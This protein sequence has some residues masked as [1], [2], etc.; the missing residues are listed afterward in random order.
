MSE[1]NT[2]RNESG[3]K[4][5]PAHRRP[6]PALLIVVAALSVVLWAVAQY[7]GD[8]GRQNFQVHEQPR[9]IAE[10]AFVDRA[11]APRSLASFA[12]KFVLLNVWATWCAPCRKEMP[13]LDELQAA[14]GGADFEVVAVSI[15]RQGLDV[16]APFYALLGLKNLAM[17]VDS[18]AD[19]Q[20]AL[21]V[22]GIPTTLLIDRSG[23]EIGR[24]IGPAEWDSAAMIQFISDRIAGKPF[25]AS[26]G[27]K[28]A[29]G[30]G[31]V[32][33]MT[34]GLGASKG[35]TGKPK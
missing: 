12:G 1:A 29:P 17:Y 8:E 34:I 30:G 23:R 32:S 24:L 25:V 35:E 4:D 13:A 20:H 21:H 11:G 16:V 10:V 18:S 2:N 9:T 15:D 22:V 26:A 31:A 3:E 19:T 28:G 33:P 6:I 5:R 27:P 7:R 14:L